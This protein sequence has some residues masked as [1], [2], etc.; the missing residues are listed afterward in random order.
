MANKGRIA[1][2]WTV[3]LLSLSTAATAWAGEDTVV[4]QVVHRGSTINGRFV[5]AAQRDAAAIYERIG[6]SFVWVTEP[7]TEVPQPHLTLQ[8]VLVSNVETDF[9]KAGLPHNALGVAP[10]GSNRAYIF[11]KRIINALARHSHQPVDVILG[12]VLAHEL[13]HL[14]LGAGHSSAGVMKAKL[15]YWSLEAPEF[16]NAEG[17]DIRERIADAR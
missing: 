10:R 16:S 17:H 2:A 5:E 12:R 7:A 6:V 14:M 9:V 11:C 15:D 8:V 4:L 1:A 3:A 13:G